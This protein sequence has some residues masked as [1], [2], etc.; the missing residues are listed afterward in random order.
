[1]FGLGAG[2]DLSTD[3]Q[4]YFTAFQF[5]PVGIAVGKKVSWFMELGLGYAYTG[6]I[7]GISWRF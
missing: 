6:Y 1:M 5:T 2:A 7:T 3:S 4:R